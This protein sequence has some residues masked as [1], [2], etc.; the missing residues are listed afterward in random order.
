MTVCPYRTGWCSLSLS[1]SV[2]SL[3]LDTHTEELFSVADSLHSLDE[4]VKKY[5]NDFVATCHTALLI[6]DGKL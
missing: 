3:C 1:A 6:V 4:L 5:I 2:L